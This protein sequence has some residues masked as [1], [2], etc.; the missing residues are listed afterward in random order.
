MNIRIRITLAGNAGY[1]G[2]EK[3]QEVTLPLEQY[4]KGV[5]AAEISN[6]PYEACRALAVVAR[7]F[8]GGKTVLEDGANDQVFFAARMDNRK[9]YPNPLKAV[10]DTEG[11]IL[12]Y[13]G[14]AIGSNAHHCSAN[15]GTTKNKSHAWK[16][17]ADVPYLIM[18]PDPW[19]QAELK[20]IMDAGEK[21]KFG[22]GVGLSQYGARYAA[23]LGVGYEEILAFYFPGTEIR[24]GNGMIQVRD[25]IAKFQQALADKWGYIWGQ[26]GGVWTKARQ[27][28]ATREM[29]VKYGSKWIGK[30]VADCSGLFAWAFK[31][32]GGYMYHGSNTMYNQYCTAKG[33]LKAG[34]E[35]KP[36]TAVFINSNGTRSHVGLYIG[37]DTVVEAK[38]TQ[39]GVVT[40]KLSHWDEWGELKGVDYDNVE[41]E[42]SMTIPGTVRKGQRSKDVTQMQ[43]LLNDQG[44]DI[45]A[46]GIFGAQTEAAVKAFQKDAGLVADGICGPLTWAALLA[47]PEDI[48]EEAPLTLEEK[49]EILWAW[50]K[51]AMG[52]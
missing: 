11:E 28:A 33:P 1:F 39:S 41:G 42:T 20:R 38:G 14:K 27:E 12:T 23:N 8:A 29:T 6:A 4:L 5:V 45:K 15:N 24:R 13:Q 50:R 48:P 7:T 18:G 34:Q 26:R 35:I 46:D 51:A 49:V 9:D 32:L 30:R 21:P 36:G 37:N 43:R 19:T 10:E 25:L 17:S 40:S 22:H 44:A 2:V 16:S 47:A 31:E 3:G 52:E